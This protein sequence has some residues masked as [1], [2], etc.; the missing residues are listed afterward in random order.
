MSKIGLFFTTILAVILGNIIFIGA[1]GLTLYFVFKKQ[2]DGIQFDK[3]T[4][5]I[6]DIQN[7]VNKLDTNQLTKLQDSVDKFAGLDL[8]SLK[9]Q[10]DSLKKFDP[11]KLDQILEQIKNI[12]SKSVASSATNQIINTTT[13]NLTSF[14]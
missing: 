10:I 11:A 5:T 12:T 3:I 9:N 13:T 4:K 8:D 6:D 2:I 7:A 1:I 14:Y